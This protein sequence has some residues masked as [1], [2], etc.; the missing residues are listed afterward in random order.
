MCV[1]CSEAIRT[2]PLCNAIF[3]RDLQA[4]KSALASC[5]DSKAA[6]SH[7]HRCVCISGS[8][9]DTTPGDLLFSGEEEGCEPVDVELVKLL[10]LRGV[11][12][13]TMLTPSLLSALI[14]DACGHDE[15]FKMVEF[16]IRFFPREMLLAVR[17]S[18][19][20][21]SGNINSAIV[22][23][24]MT[25]FQK[26]ELVKL[27]HITYG[28]GIDGAAVHYAISNNLQ[29]LVR[30][31]VSV[32]CDVNGQPAISEDVNRQPVISRTNALANLLQDHRYEKRQGVL[33]KLHD[34]VKFLVDE[35]YD[36]KRPDGV[37]H[38]VVEYAQL[39]GFD[40]LSL[41]NVEPNAALQARMLAG[42]ACKPVPCE[43]LEHVA[44]R[45]SEEHLRQVI[46]ILHTNRFCKNPQGIADAVSHVVPILRAIP[47]YVF[48]N[49]NVKDLLGPTTQSLFGF[50]KLPEIE[51]ILG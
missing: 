27:C 15:N 9:S 2:C 20:S 12:P 41:F 5:G 36:F 6:W 46:T 17:T 25:Q 31:F 28:I 3:M 21:T 38:A 43:I 34:F 22:W 7:V 47:P 48:A 50:G 19:M 32:G 49:Q 14:R 18:S 1:H 4:I 13:A 44:G 8:E 16:L 11:L 29:D 40:V 39:W 10:I 26:L 37:G 42:R 33:K 23:S 51:N 35:G 24:Y 30:Y 45:V